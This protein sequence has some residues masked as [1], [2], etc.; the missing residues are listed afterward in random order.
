MENHLIGIQEV[1]EQH[2]EVVH[3]SQELTNHIEVPQNV[4]AD[5]ENQQILRETILNDDV[6]VEM[7]HESRQ[8]V[9]VMVN[10]PH[11]QMT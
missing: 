10:R 3:Q 7:L 1:R 11:L 6:A 2:C 8:I 5:I 9:H 4:S